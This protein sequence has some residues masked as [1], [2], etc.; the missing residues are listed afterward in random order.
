MTDIFDRWPDQYDQWFRTPMGGLIKDYESALRLNM[1]TPKPK[2][3]ILDAGCGTGVFTRDFLLSGAQVTGV[4]LSLPMLLRS[5]RKLEDYPFI[6]VQGDIRR[7]PFKDDS[8]DHAVSITA[9]EFIKDAAGAVAELFRVTRS[10]GVVLVATLNRLS[11]WSTRRKAAGEKGHPLFQHAFF[12]SPE[13]LQALSP[14]RAHIKTAIHFE[15]HVSLEAARE[16]A[17]DGRA[18]DLY[19]GAFLVARWITPY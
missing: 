4:E 2:D 1:L 17:A 9:I 12:R 16:M 3:R 19:T 10:G 15:K 14:I 5:Q 7:L 11:S 8:F 6:G 18:I 13:E